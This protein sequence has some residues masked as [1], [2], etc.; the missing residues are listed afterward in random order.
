ML[1]E[2]RKQLKGYKEVGE[3]VFYRNADTFGRD[4]IDTKSFYGNKKIL[5]TYDTMKIINYGWIMRVLDTPA[6][7]LGDC[8][9]SYW[10]PKESHI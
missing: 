10:I 9:V 4:I 7:G 1:K 3:S 5:G 2:V 8:F 6:R